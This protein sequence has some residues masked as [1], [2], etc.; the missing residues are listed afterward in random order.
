MPSLTLS[1]GKTLEFSIP[2]G[3]N[4][5]TLMR[6]KGKGIVN[7]ATQHPGDQI[8]KLKVVPPYAIGKELRDFLERR[9]LTHA[10]D[11]RSKAEGF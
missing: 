6:L 10:Y 7:P 9:N 4:S 2:P 3:V 5:G 11:V 8:V 1:D